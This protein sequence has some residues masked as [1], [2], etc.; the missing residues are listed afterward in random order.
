MVGKLV[1]YLRMCGHDAAYALDRG[2]EDDDRLHDLARKEERLLLTRGRDLAAR[3]ERSLLLT[4]RDIRGQLRELAA[5]EVDLA[6]PDEPMRCGRCNGSLEA[7]EKDEST[8]EYAPDPREQQVW[9]CIECGQYFWKGSHW[10]RV[11]ATLS[12]LD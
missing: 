4:S 2:L 6:L 9:R 7:V 5:A 12:E 11:E 8:P 1:V 10:K 3:A